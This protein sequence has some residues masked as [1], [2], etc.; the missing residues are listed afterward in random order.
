MPVDGGSFHRL[1]SWSKLMHVQ[2][3]NSHLTL[4]TS[5]LIIVSQRASGYYPR[6]EMVNGTAEL[7]AASQP[8]EL[9]VRQPKE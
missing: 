3:R 8:M 5:Q 7:S 6:A 2:A 1:R 4:T 9:L